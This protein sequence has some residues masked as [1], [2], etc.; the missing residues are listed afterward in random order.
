MPTAGYLG[1]VI[2]SVSVGQISDD[3][4]AKE[5]QARHIVIEKFFKVPNSGS[6]SL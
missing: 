1:N 5:A 2:V 4:L 3:A 6:L